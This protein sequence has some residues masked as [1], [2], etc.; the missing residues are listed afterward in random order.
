M[1]G[2]IGLCVCMLLRMYDVLTFKGADCTSSRVLKRVLIIS[3]VPKEHGMQVRVK[4]ENLSKRCGSSESRV[5][6][7]Y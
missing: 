5:V 3:P 4:G 2:E 1:L 6:D 7:L